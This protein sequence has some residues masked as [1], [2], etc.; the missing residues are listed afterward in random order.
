VAIQNHKSQ[1]TNHKS[2]K[3]QTMAE[4][5]SSQKTSFVAI[6]KG[7]IIPGIITKL[8]SSEILVDINTKAEALVLEK[9]KKILNALLSSLSV[10]DKVTVQ[11][12]NPESDMGNSVVSLRRFLD[13]KLWKKI[14]EYKE[15]KEVIDITVND[16]VRGGFLAST[17][18]GI[19]GFLP[20][21]QVSFVSQV[22]EIGG[23]GSQNIIGNSVKAIILE[24]DRQTHKII[25]SQTKAIGSEDFDKEIK[26]L[27]TGQIVKGIITN[28][29]QFGI[30]TS[31]PIEDHAI[32]GFIHISDI[33][34]NN[35]SDLTTLY[36]TGDNIEASIIGFD[37]ETRRVK[38]SIKR[39]EEDPFKDRAK[40]F[41]IDK[42]VKATVL[43]II[44]SGV[45]LDLENEM[46]GLIRKDKIP[47][48]ISYKTG[49]VIDAV[50]SSIDEG[51]RRIIL[52]PS[53]TEKP[54]GYR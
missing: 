1:I 5:L 9:D 17:N 44:S 25:F 41:P 29:S 45:M 15:K 43:K 33:S 31:V 23:D 2:N 37:K 18:D 28:V 13:D 48:K 22:S 47:P 8:T 34:W 50:V 20:N 26:K 11:I 19:S 49:D 42:K 30:F 27:K 12:L 14:V 6:H 51:R 46:T 21:S 16:V 40:D 53:L 10:G 4:L 3:P 54:I 7:A 38:L 24:T 39:L 36:K 35:I 52:V 32:D